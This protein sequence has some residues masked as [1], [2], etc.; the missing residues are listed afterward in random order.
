MRSA[1]LWLVV[2][3]GGKSLQSWWPCRETDEGV[4][5]RWFHT[6]ALTLGACHSTWC[7]SQFVRMPDGQRDDGR[8][9]TVE[10]CNPARLSGAN[11]S[12]LNIMSPTASA[13]SR[14]REQRQRVEFPPLSRRPISL[15]YDKDFNVNGQPYYAGVYCH[16]VK[17]S[18]A[19]M[20][21]S[22][23]FPSINGFARS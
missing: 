20:A 13:S 5:E 10:Y 2:Y 8:R 1:P 17:Q 21:M 16:D 15:C 12:I 9:Q 19:K 14:P 22:A 3:S 4:L 7:R 11:F 23:M 6:Q 18:P